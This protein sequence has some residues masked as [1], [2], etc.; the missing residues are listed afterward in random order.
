MEGKEEELNKGYRTRRREKEENGD[1]DE[2]IKD[3]ESH[4]LRYVK[5][6]KPSFHS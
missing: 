5:L 1:T 6:D 4:I 3:S 2:N